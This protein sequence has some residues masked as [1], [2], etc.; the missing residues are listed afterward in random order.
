MAW[1]SSSD[2]YGRICGGLWC[3]LQRRDLSGALTADRLHRN[4]TPRERES[5][6]RT[7]AAAARK[8]LY[9]KFPVCPTPEKARRMQQSRPGGPPSGQKHFFRNIKLNTK[10]CLGPTS[11]RPR[12]ISRTASRACI[13]LIHPLPPAHRHQRKD[14]VRHA[15]DQMVPKAP[16]EWNR[17]WRCADEWR[18]EAGST[19]CACN[20][21]H[22]GRVIS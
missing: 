11:H 22:R 13:N 21:M 4:A 8:Q 5:D 3:V 18:T 12:G 15:N 7:V 2:K 14:C 16:K 10:S 1:C 6:P 19:A 9:S 20:A 17:L